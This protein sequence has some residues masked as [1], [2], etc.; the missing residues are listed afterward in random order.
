MYVPISVHIPNDP[1]KD[2]KD[3]KK[4]V[5]LSFL[6]CDSNFF[7]SLFHSPI[8]YTETNGDSTLNNEELQPIVYGNHIFLAHRSA[9]YADIQWRIF[10]DVLIPYFRFLA[11]HVVVCLPSRTLN[12]SRMYFC[13]L[14]LQFW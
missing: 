12:V 14:A 3:N 2:N 6:V 13:W 10:L 11:R 1:V 5:K 4:R 7:S 8:F 9:W